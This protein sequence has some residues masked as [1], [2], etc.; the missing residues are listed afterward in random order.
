MHVCIPRLDTYIQR[1]HYGRGPSA[2]TLSSCL[3][4]DLL[5]GGRG[6]GAVWRHFSPL[7]S[8]HF[9]TPNP[10]NFLGLRSTKQEKAFVWVSL[11][12]EMVLR[13]LPS[14]LC[15]GLPN[16]H[17]VPF[18]C[19]NGTLGDP[20]PLPLGLLHYHSKWTKCA[21]LLSVWL[22]VLIDHFSIWQLRKSFSLET[23]WF[24]HT[25]KH[26]LYLILLLFIEREIAR[27]HK[28]GQ[29]PWR[30]EPHNIQLTSYSK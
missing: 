8:Q 26:N 5:I 30:Q 4:R 10:S 9:P 19:E 11:G 3:F 25:T 22:T 27:L 28:L 20:A 15:S 12:S 21:L 17:P 18:C 6:W 24:T 13:Y 2:E 14:A 16:P 23:P 1:Y 7:L 29:I